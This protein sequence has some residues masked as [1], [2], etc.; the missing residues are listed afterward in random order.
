MNNRKSISILTFSLS[1]KRDRAPH[2]SSR[3][4]GARSRY[5]GYSSRIFKGI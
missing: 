3:N 5:V 1:L 2:H 4:K